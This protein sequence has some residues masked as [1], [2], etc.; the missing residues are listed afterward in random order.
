LIRLRVV[1]DVGEFE[2]LGRV[3]DGLLQRS[4]DNDVFSTWEWLWCWW[5]HFG[6]GRELR[7]LVAERGG[8]VVGIA[9]LTV[10][11]YSF[12]GLGRLRRVEFI[13]FPQA[14]YNN[15]ILLGDAV[16]CLR[17][18]ME[19]LMG[20]SDWDLIDLRDVREDSV[21]AGALSRVGGGLAFKVRFGECTVCPYIGLPGS[22][23]VFMA[24]LS[25]NMRRNLRK[26]FRR[27]CRD[28]RVGFMGQRDFGSVDEAMD[29]FF[30]L[31]QRRWRSKGERGSFSSR[32]I[33][34]FHRDVA[35]AFDERGW[36]DLRFLTV[37]GEPVAAAYTFNYGLKKYGYQTGF[38]PEFGR[39][40]VGNLLKLHL[41][42]ECI[43]RGFREYDLTRDFEPYKADWATGVRRNM[44]FRVVRRGLFAR[45]YCWAIENRFSRSLSLKL[46]THLSLG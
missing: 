19:G 36:L 42:E 39:Y 2:G 37:N 4:L 45:A 8:R 16:E 23:E 9:P 13:G 40:G 11:R 43:K 6:E 35:R 38:D 26:R 46:G 7:V 5:R 24:G 25:R 21:S 44:F 41:V 15:F 34:D 12:L 30:D 17:V 28:Y 32:R 14:D 18:F 20:F 31:H 22:I 27:L 10:S 1:S 3:W 29:V 33:R